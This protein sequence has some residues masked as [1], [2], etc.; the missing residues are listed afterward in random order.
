M[1]KQIH[2][3]FSI[4]FVLAL[5]ITPEALAASKSGTKTIYLP[6]TDDWVSIDA[7]RTGNSTK[8]ET[9][10]YAVYPP[11]GGKEDNYTRVKAR[12]HFSGK[13]ITGEKTL[14][15]T[16]SDTTKFDVP[17]V[18]NKILN[19]KFQYKRNNPNYD[20]NAHVYYNAR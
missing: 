12:V 8:T 13:Y 7:T 20:A 6:K 15:E 2:K 18:A 14:Y 10:L 9:Q 16:N 5:L 1:Y 4:I 11:K 3:I 19:I 17:D